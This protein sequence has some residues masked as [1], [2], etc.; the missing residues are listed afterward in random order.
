MLVI[1]RRER[2]SHPQIVGGVEVPETR[3]YIFILQRE[4]GCHPQMVGG[5]E[6]PETR[7]YIFILRFSSH[8]FRLSVCQALVPSP[9]M[10]R[11]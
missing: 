8:N 10:K 6:L 9:S 1:L 4:R 5:V 11:M 7:L 2:G 3:L